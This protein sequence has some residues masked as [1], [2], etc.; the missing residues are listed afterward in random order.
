MDG[1]DGLHNW[2]M[3]IKLWHIVILSACYI[4]SCRF[5][6]NSESKNNKLPLSRIEEFIDK[7]LF[8]NEIDSAILLIN[9]TLKNKELNSLEKGRLK[10]K[11]GASLFQKNEIA[12]SIKLLNAGTLDIINSFN[13]ADSS[14][15]K[16]YFDA[17]IL[18]A[19]NYRLLQ[20]FDS[21][22]YYLKKVEKGLKELKENEMYYTLKAEVF[23]W[24]GLVYFDMGSI[25]QALNYTRN[26]ID[27]RREHIKTSCKI[28]D[29]YLLISEIY[30]YNEDFEKAK[31]YQHKALEV[32]RLCYSDTSL[33]YAEKVT[34]LGLIYYESKDYYK[35]LHYFQ[36]CHDILSKHLPN[37]SPYFASTYNNLGDVYCKLGLEEK[38]ILQYQKALKIYIEN[39]Y[40]EDIKVIYHNL[41]NVYTS[42][43]DYLK[44]YENYMKSLSISK[45][46][47]SEKN[48]FTCFTYQQLGKL[49]LK[50]KEY[51]N[52]IDFF[53]KAIFHVCDTNIFDN[54]L[55]NEVIYSSIISE[56]ELLE[57][58]Y[59]KGYVEYLLFIQ[60]NDLEYLAKSITT[61]SH[62]TQIIDVV[63]NKFDSEEAKILINKIRAPLFS[64]F[65]LALLRMRESR[66][67]YDSDNEILR[68]I[69]RKKYT[70]LRSIMH[71]EEV[72]CSLNLP[73]ETIA[74]EDTLKKQIRFLKNVISLLNNR[75]MYSN[76]ELKIF[77][78]KLFSCLFSYDSLIH[79]IKKEY[80]EY[81]DNLYAFKYEG[82]RAIQDQITNDSVVILNYDITDSIMLVFA[83]SKNNYI[84]FDTI[85]SSNLKKIKDRLIK[86]IVFAEL[87]SLYR[88]SK[89]L[90]Q[91]LI[92]PLKEYLKSYNHL[93]IIPDNDIADLPFEV[94]IQGGIN[95]QDTLNYLVK[96]YI[97][98]YQYSLNL[99]SRKL[100]RNKKENQ[101]S[102]KYYYSGFAPFIENNKTHLESLNILP[103]S[104]QE[105]KEIF[106]M[107]QNEGMKSK[108]FL[109][110]SASRKNISSALKNSK[111]VHLATHSDF[112]NEAPE[113]YFQI[114]DEEDY[115][116]NIN[117]YHEVLDGQ[118]DFNNP[119][120]VYLSDVYNMEI[121]SDLVTLGSCS[122]GSGNKISGEGTISLVRGFY[123]SGANNIVYSL[124]N[125]SDEHTMEF[126]LSFY[127]YINKG[128]SYSHALQKTKLDFI[129]S[130]YQLPQFWSGILIN[131]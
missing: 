32:V 64:N 71:Y 1:G 56:V 103:S 42:L 58:L 72:I 23:S 129:N 65:L 125:I 22:L 77:N 30:T 43:G 12:N 31:V 92:N 74:L 99:L 123:C 117:N 116:I 128:Y 78:D 36:I 113:H 60:G 20:E 67:S 84:L 119:N 115:L 107:F 47:N 104:E 109:G 127:K 13:K 18:Q 5:N 57:S 79:Q 66:Q 110:K 6:S 39:G 19:N 62:A 8:N 90:Y 68:C 11:L 111:I 54:N 52:A 83:I 46:L 85:I 108:M 100:S 59:Y 29:N 53:R 25:N 51:E 70:A 37:N 27:I 118:E 45:K 131:N 33:F 121:Y 124:W 21:S 15:I 76:S 10:I 3:K 61:F 73:L 126:M 14:T 55:T 38:G 98:S 44:A 114:L 101:V 81:V 95:S 130:N 40:T 50:Q 2:G 26:A 105:V 24:R 80:P 102:Y 122:S 16:L 4:G 89:Y 69:E 34:N 75:N 88:D 87:T 17:L 96:D 7:Q 106:E 120:K 49:A 41:G 94:L 86:S 82:I 91:V 112:N 35:A 93:I 48:V 97:I 28:A 9:T 63:R